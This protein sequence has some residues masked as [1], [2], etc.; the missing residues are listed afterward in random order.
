MVECA[1]IV[2]KGAKLRIEGM[3]ASLPASGR[4]AGKVLTQQKFRAE[5]TQNPVACLW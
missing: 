1:L 5:E 4:A 2:S 3:N